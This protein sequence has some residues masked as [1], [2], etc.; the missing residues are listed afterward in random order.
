M[1]KEKAP[2]HV[3]ENWLYDGG[4]VGSDVNPIIEEIMVILTK[5]KITIKTA[6]QILEDTIKAIDQEAIL[7]DRKVM[8]KIIQADQ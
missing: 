6:K 5:Q 1:S 4:I 2:C 8:G 3:P 7:R